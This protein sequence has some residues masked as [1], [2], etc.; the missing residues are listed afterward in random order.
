MFLLL[1][2]MKWY[3]SSM[4]LLFLKTKNRDIEI[5]GLVFKINIPRFWM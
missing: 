5:L 3:F 2:D 1:Q 4:E